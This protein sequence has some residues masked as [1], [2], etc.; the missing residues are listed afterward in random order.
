MVKKIYTLFFMCILQIN[1]LVYA[2][3]K[4]TAKNSKMGTATV[5]ID[6]PAEAP[7]FRFD[8]ADL[9]QFGDIAG[10]LKEIRLVDLKDGGPLLDKIEK[11]IAGLK[12]NS[13]FDA[14][15]L[16]TTLAKLKQ[17]TILDAQ[18][19]EATIDGLGKTIAETI[20]AI[21]KD[22]FLDVSA[23]GRELEKL[24]TNTLLDAKA[25][26]E[27][28]EKLKQG[29]LLDAQALQQTL[30]EFFKQFKAATADLT[31]KIQPQDLA[32]VVKELS[33]IKVTVSPATIK[34]A[35]NFVKEGAKNVA[36]GFI[37]GCSGYDMLF[38]NGPNTTNMSLASVCTYQLATPKQRK[39]IC[40]ILCCR[41]K[42]A[43]KKPPVLLLSSNAPSQ[44]EGRRLLLTGPKPDQKTNSHR[45]T[46]GDALKRA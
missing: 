39:S 11:I 8:S 2:A 44:P 12:Q 28:F 41:R 45:E 25:L 1:C 26:G 9:K 29:S 38:G 35:D 22:S 36:A 42:N 10:Q 13:L 33:N 43:R 20:G 6:L 32:E 37:L 19:F 30:Q 16:D 34:G 7:A 4:T 23:L 27:L 31:I 18:K 5:D 15:A 24:K 46:L 21:K 17:G 14:Q 40:D 3:T